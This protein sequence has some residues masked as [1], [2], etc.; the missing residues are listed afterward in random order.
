MS[1]HDVKTGKELLEEDFI[2][3]SP[4]WHAEL[5]LMVKSKVRNSASS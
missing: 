5:E 2:K 4:K 1:E 3:A